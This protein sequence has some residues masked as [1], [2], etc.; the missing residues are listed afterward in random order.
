MPHV[1][2]G[3]FDVCATLDGVKPERQ[4]SPTETI[5]ASATTSSFLRYTNQ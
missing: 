2:V 5:G 1:A 4:L 3:R